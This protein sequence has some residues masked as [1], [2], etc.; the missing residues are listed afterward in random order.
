[1]TKIIFTSILIVFICT[2]SVTPYADIYKY[3][4]KKGV[5][6][7]T[8]I[9]P[10]G[11]YERIPVEPAKSRRYYDQ[12]IKSK[13]KKYNIEPAMIKAVITAESN[14]DSKAVSKKG[15]IG[16]MQLMPPTAR[17][18]Q[19]QNPFDPEQNIEGGTKYLKKLLDRFNG[20]IRLALAA[21]NAGPGKVEKS[22]GIPAITETNKFVKNVIEIYKGKSNNKPVR[23]YKVTYDDGTILYT[24]TPYPYKRYK[25][26]NF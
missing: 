13:S 11:E 2:L 20:N 24:N 12:I 23:I 3:I 16:L 22:R 17:D 7:Y 18:M 8:N 10:D 5:A 9:P 15:A 25:L 21:Y 14:W 4:D 19:V 6:H 1:M 26:S